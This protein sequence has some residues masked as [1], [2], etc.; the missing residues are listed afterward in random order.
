V[1]SEEFPSGWH[2]SLFTFPF[3]FSSPSGEV[4]EMRATGNGKKEIV[5][6][7]SYI[8]SSENGKNLLCDAKLQKL[9][10]LRK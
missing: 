6:C 5:I 8:G 9:D 2:F 4:E 7:P 10:K 3:S 1:K